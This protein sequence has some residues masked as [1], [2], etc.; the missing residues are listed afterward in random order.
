LCSRV[1]NFENS[2]PKD[3]VKDICESDLIEN[4]PKKVIVGDEGENVYGSWSKNKTK[5]I[6]LGRTFCFSIVDYSCSII[7]SFK[8]IILCG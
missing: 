3:K 2:S 5:A 7:F 1:S 6:G 8:K 4:V